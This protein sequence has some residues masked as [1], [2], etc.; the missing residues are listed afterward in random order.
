MCFQHEGCFET[1]VMLPEPYKVCLAGAVCLP[2]AAMHV[3][4]ELSSQVT[5]SLL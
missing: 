4:L 5:W 2:T 3:G 1:G